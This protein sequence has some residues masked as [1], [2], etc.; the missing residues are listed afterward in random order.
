MKQRS[1]WVQFRELAGVLWPYAVALIILVGLWAGIIA[2]ATAI[3]KA[4]WQ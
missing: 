2:G 1:A 4:V 3:V